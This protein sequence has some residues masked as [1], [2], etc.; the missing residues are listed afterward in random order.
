[1]A[2]YAWAETKPKNPLCR[3]KKW[4]AARPTVEESA[5]MEPY[6]SR[7]QS[8]GQLLM[9]DVCTLAGVV[10]GRKERARGTYSS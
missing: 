2:A 6:S 7:F 5:G 9:L 1:V 10:A 8:E 3:R 4:L